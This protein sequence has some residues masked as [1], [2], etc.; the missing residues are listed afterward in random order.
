MPRL[1]PYLRA[2]AF[3]VVMSL[4]LLLLAPVQALARRRGW[5]I[6]NAI[7]MGFCRAICAI[8]GVR[9]VS[10]ALPTRPAPRLI[11]ANHVSWTDV[12]ALS[13][14]APFLFLAKSEV[15]RWPVLGLLARLQGAIFVTR[16]ARMDVA[17]VNG[18]LTRALGEGRDLVVFPEGT[19]SDGARV[20]PFKP[21]HFDAM[22]DAA[23]RA[24]V[25]PAAIVYLQDDAPVDVGWYAE[26][27]FLPHLWRLMKR[28]GVT[29][30]ID[31]GAAIDPRGRDRKSLAREA[32]A[33]VAEL[34]QA[35]RDQ[36]ARARSGRARSGR[37]RSPPPK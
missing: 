30:R 4:T 16:G 23:A 3:L 15:A 19:S 36:R 10:S 13:S 20:L 17:R 18:E 32:Q 26:M 14:L 11:V 1:L 5:A 8:L 2:F 24:R 6:Q 34:L 9:V 21:A 31:F 7:Q 33:R 22:R 28:G 35:A 27:T 37:A 25:V 29:C 12:I